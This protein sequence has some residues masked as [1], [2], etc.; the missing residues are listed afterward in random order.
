MRLRFGGLVSCS[1]VVGC[2]RA[3]TPAP[4]P[5]SDAAV[6]ATTAEDEPVEPEAP[7]ASTEA[8]VD[9]IDFVGPGG[10]DVWMDDGEAADACADAGYPQTLDAKTVSQ[11]GPYSLGARLSIVHADGL[12]EPNVVAVHCHAPEGEDEPGMAQLK[13]SLTVPSPERVLG[14]TSESFLMIA[15][16]RVDPKAG[17]RLPAAKTDVDPTV[18]KT[19]RAVAAEE[20]QHIADRC[21]EDS[22][23]GQPPPP[24]TEADL[25]EVQLYPVAGRDGAG[26]FA[27]F[28]VVRCDE[29]T[30]F[31]VLLDAKGRVT[32]HWASNNDVGLLWITDLDGDGDDE[33]GLQVTWLEDGM[34][35]I[36]I[37]YRH[38]GAWKTRM[39]YVS[40]S[41]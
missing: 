38:E 40:D 24:L 13:L 37:E 15:G 29:E 33:L 14:L 21:A 22:D 12:A 10:D 34:E 16:M 20:T 5:P 18:R 31:G 11:L 4:V 41:P 8:L 27:S 9:A 2:T 3:A 1:I 7:A 17:L 36:S 19:L 32:K 23:S 26:A 6:E 30:R 39:M 28:H 25:E 35:E